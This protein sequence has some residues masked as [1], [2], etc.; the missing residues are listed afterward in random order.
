LH[1]TDTDPAHYP[2]KVVIFDSEWQ[3]A[4]FGFSGSGRGNIHDG[5]RVNAVL[6]SASCPDRAATDGKMSLAGR[7]VDT[8]S[9]LLVLTHL[10]GD[11]TIVHQC[12]MKT[13]VKPYVFWRDSSSGNITTLTQDQLKDRKQEKQTA[14]DSAMGSGTLAVDSVPSGADIYSDGAFVGNTPAALKLGPGKHA[15]RVVMPSFADWQRE[16]A[17]QAGDDLRLKATLDKST[18]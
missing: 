10:V 1:P 2:L 16:I 17:I 11:S 5:D 6:F 8:N 12:E 18:H 4:T 13:D 9:R 15:I 7:W 3:K 14:Q